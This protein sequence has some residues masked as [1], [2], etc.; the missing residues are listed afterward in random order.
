M[1]RKSHLGSCFLLLGLLCSCRAILQSGEKNVLSQ[2]TSFSIRF[3]NET[4][5]RALFLKELEN[6][7]ETKFDLVINKNA[8]NGTVCRCELTLDIGE[9][10]FP[11]ALGEDGSL[12]EENRMINVSY[13]LK[14]RDE[15]LRR[16]LGVLHSSSSSVFK[17][18][19]YIRKQKEDSNMAENLAENIFLDLVKQLP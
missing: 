4:L 11:S 16:K 6:S 14:I 15:T 18:S 10:D 8:K 13:N 7:L 19:D 2:C 5:D 17:Y 3:E 9:T 1:R 12:R